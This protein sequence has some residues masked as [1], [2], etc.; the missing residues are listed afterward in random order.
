MKAGA[1]I[2]VASLAG[3]D[4][5]LR[6]RVPSH[7]CWT[8]FIHSYFSASMPV[9]DTTNTLLARSGGIVTKLRTALAT[10]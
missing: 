9:P 7:L 6:F 2:T 3:T 5:G 1:P 8:C 10:S 4:R